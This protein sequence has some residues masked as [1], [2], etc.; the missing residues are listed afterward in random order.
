MPTFLGA[1]WYP[2]G[3]PLPAK[4]IH[5]AVDLTIEELKLKYWERKASKEEQ[6]ILKEYVLYYI[7]APIF[8]IQFENEEQQEY[9]REKMSL[10]DILDLLLDAGID[11]L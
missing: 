5:T 9:F 10:D 3:T 2:G 8:N 1:P 7:G 6:E 4:N 11:P